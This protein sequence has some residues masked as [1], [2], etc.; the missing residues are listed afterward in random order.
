MTMS[1]EPIASGAIGWP[2]K[3]EKPNVATRK[4][5]PIN[6]TRYFIILDLHAMYFAKFP[7]AKLTLVIDSIRLVGPVAIE[8]GTRLLTTKDAASQ[9]RLRYIAVRTKT[10]ADWQIA[11]LREFADHPP[12]APHDHLQP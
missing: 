3:T 9:A 1:A 4:N 12:T 7:G 6:S 10:A 2:P 8:E 11:S 5:R